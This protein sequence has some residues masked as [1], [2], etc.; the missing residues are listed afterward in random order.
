MLSGVHPNPRQSASRVRGLK[1]SWR[2]FSMIDST[3][4][5]RPDPAFATTSS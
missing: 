1:L 3:G 5:E 2:A 4:L